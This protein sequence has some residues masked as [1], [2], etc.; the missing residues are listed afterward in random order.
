MKLNIMKKTKTQI[1][2]K[3]ERK[4]YRKRKTEMN[5]NVFNIC[6]MT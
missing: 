4:K 6:S 1:P 2:Q 3:K 5:L